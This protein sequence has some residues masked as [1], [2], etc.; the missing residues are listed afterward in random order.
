MHF[1]TAVCSTLQERKANDFETFCR[2][3]DAN[4]PF[5][6]VVDGANVA[7]YGQNFADG[8]FDFG[9]IETAV[10]HVRG[11]QPGLKPLVVSSSF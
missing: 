2:W 8:G 7:L 6:C 3:L 1:G 5:G 11:R 9:Q 10:Q 4:G